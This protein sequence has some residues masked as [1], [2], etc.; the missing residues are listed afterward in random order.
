MRL[1]V[2]FS[3]PSLESYGAALYE[4]ACRTLR[5]SATNCG[6]MTCTARDSIRSCP[7][8]NGPTTCPTPD[9][10]LPSTRIMWPICNGPKAWW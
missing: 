9:G 6:A 7:A 8:R 5:A 1:L 4:T 2:V 10:S 3:H